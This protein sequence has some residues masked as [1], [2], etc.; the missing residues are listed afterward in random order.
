LKKEPKERFASSLEELLRHKSFSKVSVSELADHCGLSR[1][2]FYR[3]FSDKYDC[4]NW[5]YRSKIAEIISDNKEISSWK[6]LV[7]QIMTFLW[8]KKL[9]FSNIA[10]Y[11]DQNSIMECIYDC[12]TTYAKNQISETLN[13]KEISEELVYS[14]HMYIVGTISAIE[15]WLKEDEQKS[16]AWVSAI[17]CDNVPLPI[18]KYFKADV[19]DSSSV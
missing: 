12:G 11:Q 2:T 3:N 4:M 6:S 5:V 1:A 8:E 16:P 15:H 14:I 19:G 17:I 7:M 10:Y 13:G 9:Y 18:S